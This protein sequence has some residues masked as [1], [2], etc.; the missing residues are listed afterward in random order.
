MVIDA[1]GNFLSYSDSLESAIMINREII[2]KLK[3]NF[4]TFSE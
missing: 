4:F 2:Q 3:F 1:Y